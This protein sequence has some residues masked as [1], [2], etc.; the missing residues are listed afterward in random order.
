MAEESKLNTQS[1][2][3]SSTETLGDYMRRLGYNV[4]K[5]TDGQGA[6]AV[7]FSNPK[8]IIWSNES[9]KPSK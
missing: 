6:M 2:S 1:T 7:I 9:K 3:S 4:V 5:R 8:N